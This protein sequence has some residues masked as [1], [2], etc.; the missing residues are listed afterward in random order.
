MTGICN[1]AMLSLAGELRRRRF[2]I[3]RREDA[4]GGAAFVVTDV[5]NAGVDLFYL[6]E[7]LR[8]RLRP[9][10]WWQ[11]GGNDAGSSGPQK[12]APGELVFCRHERSSQWVVANALPQDTPPVARVSSDRAPG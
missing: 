6:R 10:A 2:P 5:E 9:S 8:R 7:R 3:R 11:P 4:I 1:H 12:A